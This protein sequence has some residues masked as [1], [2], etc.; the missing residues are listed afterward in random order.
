MEQLPC[1]SLLCA[2]LGELDT[3]KHSG[4]ELQR[5][6][7]LYLGDIRFSIEPLAKE[8]KPEDC[9]T[10]LQVLGG[11]LPGVQALLLP[12]QGGAVR[13]APAFTGGLQTGVLRPS[14]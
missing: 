12:D 8:N 3:A 14:P 4:L 10:Y 1:V 6:S 13:F 7:R 9:R 5:L 11:G 2:L